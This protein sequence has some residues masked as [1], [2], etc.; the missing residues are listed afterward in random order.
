MSA[1]D[2]DPADI[3]AAVYEVVSYVE[4]R[5]RN[6]TQAKRAARMA[7]VDMGFQSDSD[8]DESGRDASQGRESPQGGLRAVGSGSCG[9]TKDDVRA[10]RGPDS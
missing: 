2:A 4:T 1:W 3:D 7:D 5:R 6:G 8:V 10:V 9:A